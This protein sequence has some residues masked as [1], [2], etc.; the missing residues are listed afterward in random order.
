MTAAA[1]YQAMIATTVNHVIE[2]IVRSVL[3]IARCAIPH[4]VWGVLMNV[5]HA[6]SRYA[7]AVLL[8]ARIAKRLTVR[9]V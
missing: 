2:I 5:P 1:L 4:C 9:I 7:R 8:N 6:M 3:R